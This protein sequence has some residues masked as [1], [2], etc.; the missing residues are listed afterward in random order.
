MKWNA[1][2]QTIG[3]CVEAVQARRLHSGIEAT[4]LRVSSTGRGF[5][6]AVFEDFLRRRAGLLVVSEQ[7]PATRRRQVG[8]RM[9]TA[10][11]R[12]SQSAVPGTATDIEARSAWLAGAWLES[13]A[14]RSGWAH[15]A[16]LLLD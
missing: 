11:V 16:Y 13:G 3:V 8:R 12:A 5:R 4:I 15:K 2:R 10:A 14:M 6:V 9:R 7:W 1:V